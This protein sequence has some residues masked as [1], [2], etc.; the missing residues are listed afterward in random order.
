[1]LSGALSKAGLNEVALSIV[2][3]CIRRNED[4]E[5][6]LYSYLASIHER[7]GEIAEAAEDIRKAIKIGRN[8]EAYY[9]ELALLYERHGQ[10]SLALANYERALEFGSSFSSPFRLELESRILQLKGVLGKA[11]PSL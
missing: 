1:M 10:L 11:N 6:M 8:K 4:S 5:P 9:F 7:R 2:N 3:R